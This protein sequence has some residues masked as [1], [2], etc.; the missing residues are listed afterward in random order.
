MKKILILGGSSDI[1]LKVINLFSK[2]NWKIYAHF[3]KNSKKLKNLKKTCKNLNL[4]KFNFKN[5]QNSEIKIRKTFDH[6]YHSIVNL[7]GYI[8]NKSFNN[9]K[10]KDTLEAISINALIPNLILKNNLG[11]M[12]KEK[13]GRIV[14]GSALG[15]P[16]GGGEYSYNYNLS[17][18][19]LE[20][21][22]GKFREWAKKN[23]LINNVRIGHTNTKIHKKMRKT[24]FGKK[25]ITLIPI[26][27]MASKEEM[28]EY[29][30]F[31]GT[32]KNSFM[33]KETISATGG[34]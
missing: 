4:I 17:K 16:Y 32:E 11:F 12:I 20:F 10:I 22:P 7:I 24:I 5:N 23:V 15:I 14:N 27:R 21:I 1:G 33:T 3:N 34:E 2:N 13:W 29:L 19:C 30:Y 28:A 31:L 18:H 8:D 9:T 6:G 26:N 25:R